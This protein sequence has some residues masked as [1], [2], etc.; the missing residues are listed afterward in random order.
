MHS[1]AQRDRSL[2]QQQQFTRRL[3]CLEVAVRLLRLRKRIDMLDPQFELA[4]ANHAEHSS[5]ALLQLFR[6]ED[7]GAE[8]RPRQ[9]NRSLLREH[10]R[11]NG[12]NW[13][14]RSA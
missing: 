10:Q 14:A 4:I 2:R 5:S 1:S 11:I 13:S 9:E 12:R 7:V 6:S 8:R 3:P